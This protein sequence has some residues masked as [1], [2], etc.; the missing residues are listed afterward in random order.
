MMIR[1]ILCYLALTAF[2]SGCIEFE[3]DS[4]S[5]SE[6]GGVTQSSNQQEVTSA[7]IDSVVD[8]EGATALT[9][10]VTIPTSLTD[11]EASGAEEVVVTAN[12]TFTVTLAVDEADVPA[13][14]KVGGYLLELP[15]G[16]QLFVEASNTTGERADYGNTPRTIKSKKSLP[17]VS[18][19]DLSPTTRVNTVANTEIEING[20]SSSDFRLDESIN[21]LLIRIIPLLVSASAGEVSSIDDI[22]LTDVSNWL[23]VQELTMSV[24]AVATNPIQIT[25]TWDAATDLDLW[26]IEP[27]ENKIYFANMV[28][29]TSLGWL[30]FDDIDGYGPENITFNYQLPEGDYDIYVHHFD[31][32][33]ATNYTVTM[34]VNG[35]TQTFDGDFPETASGSG[36]IGGDSVDKITTL[37]IDASIN[38]ALTAPKPLSD[39]AGVWKSSEVDDLFMEITSDQINLYVEI[40]SSCAGYTVMSGTNIPTGIV[41][42]NNQLV[43]TGAF[44]GM[45]LT[46]EDLGYDGIVMST[47]TKPD[48]CSLN[49]FEALDALFAP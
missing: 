49:D 2:L 29:S 47:Y 30:D 22:D 14:K 26:V 25:L 13:G 31:G 46:D 35:T 40:E 10:A 15:G 1:N 48:N 27:D 12:S 32:E 16:D 44:L 34:T 4:S 21:D 24:V 6:T 43:I 20:W 17:A 5:D 7:N 45:Q 37:S 19:R 18:T 3:D 38:D 28:S 23:G 33:V 8:I 11:I 36:I 41:V 42:E 9:Q 39:Y